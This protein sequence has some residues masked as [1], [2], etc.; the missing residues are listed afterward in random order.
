M[1]QYFIHFMA[2][3]SY[4]MDTYILFMHLLVNSYLGCSHS[5]INNTAINIYVKVFCGTCIFNYHGYIPR[6]GTVAS[7]GNFMF[8]FLKSCQTFPNRM[9]YLTIFPQPYWHL[10]LSIFIITSHPSRYELA[11]HCG[12]DLHFPKDQWC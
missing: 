2:I 3:I 11:S 5:I 10:F 4:W 8:N 1:Y 12:F 7:Y 9:H 6:N